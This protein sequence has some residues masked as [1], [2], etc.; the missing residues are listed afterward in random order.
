MDHNLTPKAPCMYET[1]V[2]IFNF[3]PFIQ[4]SSDVALTHSDSHLCQGK[5]NHNPVPVG[6]NDSFLPNKDETK[7][8]TYCLTNH[9]RVDQEME[10]W[11]ACIHPCH[12]NRHLRTFLIIM[13]MDTHSPVP[14][15]TPPTI[16]WLSVD[17]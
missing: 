12:D 10:P 17:M 14:T 7:G 8:N 16:L 6:I 9:A 1:H 4:S 2:Q 15:R 3:T 5:N 11:R 13:M